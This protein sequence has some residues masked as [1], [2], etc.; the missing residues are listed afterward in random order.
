MHLNLIWIWKYQ[1]HF[2]P[3]SASFSET[4]NL[5]FIIFDA[6]IDDTYTIKVSQLFL[7]T[8][9]GTEFF[10]IG[11]THPITPSSPQTNNT[12]LVSS[13]PISYVDSTGQSV[14]YLEGTDLDGDPLTFFIETDPSFGTAS[15]P[16]PTSSN[17][18]IVFY[19]PFEGIQYPGSD[20]FTVKAFDGTVSSQNEGFANLQSTTNESALSGQDHSGTIIEETITT[21]GFSTLSFSPS[22]EPVSAIWGDTSALGVNLFYDTDSSSEIVYIPPNSHR[23]FVLPSVSNIDNIFSTVQ[24][25]QPNDFV[26]ISY[27]DEND[28]VILNSPPTANPLSVVGTKG[29]L[30]EI[31]LTGSDP[32]NDSLEFSLNSLPSNGILS[33][34]TSPLPNLT[35]SSSSIDYIPNPSFTGLDSFT[36]FVH[37]EVGAMSNTVT[38]SI[39]VV[40][41]DSNDPTA[42]DQTI[43]TNKNESID[44]V[45]TASTPVVNDP[46]PLEFTID[47]GAPGQ[48]SLDTATPAT[49]LDDISAKV[50]YTP[51]FNYFGPDSFGFTVEQVF[52]LP[53]STDAGMVTIN[54]VDPPNIPPVAVG[55]LLQVDEDSI[56]EILDVLLNDLDVEGQT[57]LINSFDDDGTFGDVTKSLDETQILF[58]PQPD[59]AGTTSFVYNIDDGEDTSNPATVFVTVNNLPDAP[60]AF[61]DSVATLVDTVLEIDVLANDIEIDPG[62]I[63][64]IDSKDD[65]GSDGTATIIN[66]GT[67]ISFTPDVGFEGTTSFNYS[68]IDGT[69]NTDTATVTLTFSDLSGFAVYVSS[70]GNNQVIPFDALSGTNTGDFVTQNE[71]GLSGPWGLAIDS[72]NEIAYVSSL[73]TT[74]VLSYNTLTGEFIAPIIS[75][76]DGLNSPRGLAID[77]G[78]N[79]YVASQDP[80]Q[81]LRYDFNTQNVSVFASSGNLP[82]PYA[83][84]FGQDGKLYV[85]DF[86]GEII[87]FDSQGNLDQILVLKDQNLGMA[88]GLAIGPDNKLYVGDRDDD[89]IIRFHNDGTF[90]KVFITPDTDNNLNNPQGLE[91]GPDGKLY[92]SSYNTNNVLRFNP[93]GSF[94]GVYISPT[95]ILTEP[96]EIRF[97]PIPVDLSPP[98]VY[99]RGPDAYPRIE[100]PGTFQFSFSDLE[101]EITEA[102][103]SINGETH[104]V[105]LDDPLW[106]LELPNLIGYQTIT[107]DVTNS[108]GKSTPYSTSFDISNGPYIA[109]YYAMPSCAT[110]PLHLGIGATV[111][112]T[113]ADVPPTT[114]YPPC[115]FYESPQLV[116]LTPGVH[117]TTYYTTNGSIPTTSSK[118]YTHPIIISDSS[119]LKFFTVDLAGNP[120][121][122]LSEEYWFDYSPPQPYQPDIEDPVIG[123]TGSSIV[124]PVGS[125]YT[126]LGATITDNDPEYSSSIVI[127]GA[128]VDTSNPGNYIVTYNAPADEAGN[129]PDE[130][131][132][133]ITVIDSTVDQVA[134][135]RSTYYGDYTQWGHDQSDPAYWTSVAQQM[136]AKFPDSTPGGVLVV[137]SVDGD[138]SSA[139]N[140]FMPFPAPAGSYPNVTFGTTDD[141]E[142]LLDAYDAAGLSI[143]LQVEPADADV[144]MLMDL[145]LNQ[146]QHHSS[147]LGFGVDVYS[148]K[149]VQNQG[150]GQALT[151]SEVNAWASQV[152]TFDP[153]YELVLTHWDSSY[154]SNARPANV[155]FITNTA[156]TSSLSELTTEYIS[157]IDSFGTSKTGF[158]IGDP[159]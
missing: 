7:S 38:V 25:G 122:I 95:G 108:D 148:Y 14:V 71:A 52:P 16:I 22:S 76:T 92:V 31:I 23:L 86:N 62:D 44:I 141:L 34:D 93:D 82:A 150:T 96:R 67:K 18:A 46:E 51:N 138:P 109:V 158:L 45:L 83:M 129:T 72:D 24:Y 17:S 110:P 156:Y 120:G 6:P 142:P 147:V 63:I 37:D 60:I 104:I 107:A 131:S 145:V 5:E 21:T 111:Y 154:L 133:T 10:A 115:G 116:T 42:H 28:T 36:F 48:G 84:A 137:G 128:S 152:Q 15:V 43:F 9:G 53:G 102:K 75:Q 74:E 135:F 30:L 69:G 12:P 151:D 66:G 49:L 27:F 94:D 91:F 39:E 112:I 64:T 73:F 79:V 59:F 157:W 78:N 106:K 149:H 99:H 100:P 65:S 19:E 54:V 32:E 127:G 11:S 87:R 56:N 118:V 41:G 146:Y 26:Q 1:I 101:T 57:L 8:V 85:A 143:Y 40:E 113:H 4:Q 13:P 68:I 81:I 105:D 88:T 126:E 58:T 121:P 139:T 2:G 114:A 134:G 61:D 124:I 123:T 144:S 77:S 98:L 3:I 35:S 132:I 47:L 159:I 90:D 33:P 130:K 125:T 117:G 29:A 97:A 153:T 140:T 50:T 55:D 103:I 70:F 89:Q 119:Y 20:F 80:P 155:M 136:S